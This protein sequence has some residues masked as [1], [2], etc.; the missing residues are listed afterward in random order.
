[1]QVCVVI[2]NDRG[3][4][5]SLDVHPGFANAQNIVSFRCSELQGYE[6][7]LCMQHVTILLIRYHTTGIDS[8]SSVLFSKNYDLPGRVC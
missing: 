4:H 2:G 5:R 1:M 7:Q 3:M 6:F 8:E